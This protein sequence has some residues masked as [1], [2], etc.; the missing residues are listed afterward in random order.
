MAK[1]E[2]LSNFLEIKQQTDRDVRQLGPLVSARYEA[3]S[4]ASQTIITLPFVVVQDT[5]QK[6]A[7]QLYIDGFLLREGAANDY[8]FTSVVNNTSAEV[9]LT[10]A[11][12]ADL[13]I[14]AL[15]IGAYQEQFP[16]PSS[17]TAS[18]NAQIN[19]ISVK[20]SNTAG[21]TLT[22]SASN[23]VPFATVDW[24]NY[25]NWVTDTFTAP[26]D[27]EYSFVGGIV[28]ATGATWASGDFVKVAIQKNGVD[29]TV[30]IYPQLAQTAPI[31]VPFEFKMKLLTGQTAKLNVNPTK[32]AAGNVTLN[33]TAGYNTIA[34]TKIGK[35]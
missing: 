31:G 3:T 19:T 25:T 30:S 21:T 20:Y 35:Y 15:K 34:I 16:N 6:N 28:I 7:F 12:V 14:I 4:T 18:L 29:N 23:I 8:T 5:V 1:V 11:I 33:T 22:K 13:N 9:T 27:G 26:Q 10:T 32:A 24:D 2:S 17:V